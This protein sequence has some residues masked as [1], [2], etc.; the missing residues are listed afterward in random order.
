MNWVRCIVS[1]SHLY[2]LCFDFITQHD[3]LFE[4]YYDLVKFKFYKKKHK[5]PHLTHFLRG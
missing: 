4:H 1:V 3:S 2:M 5:E